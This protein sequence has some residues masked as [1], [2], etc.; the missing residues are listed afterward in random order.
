MSRCWNSW[1]GNFLDQTGCNS[2]SRATPD[3]M[4][5]FVTALASNPCADKAHYAGKAGR[6]AKQGNAGSARIRDQPGGNPL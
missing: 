1:V 5:L 2:D 4:D 6:L 3:F